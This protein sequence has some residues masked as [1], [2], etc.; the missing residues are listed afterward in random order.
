MFTGML[1]VE[2]ENRLSTKWPR[3]EVELLDIQQLRQ[4]N[5]QL[6]CQAN[7]YKALHGRAK[8]KQDQLSKE[9]EQLKARIRYLQKRLY[10]RKSEKSKRH[11]K[12]AW[13]QDKD[14]SCDD[15]RAR[16]HQRGAPGHARRDY[17][18]LPVKQEVYDLKDPCCPQCGL[19]YDEAPFVD[20]EDSQQIE[21]E[22]CAHRRRIHRKTYKKCCQCDGVPGIVTAPGPGKLIPKG[23]FGVSIW[24]TILLEKYSYQRPIHRLLDAFKDHEIDLA[25]GTIGDGLKRIAPLFEPVLQAISEKHQ[26]QSHM[27][28]DETRWLVF[29]LVEGKGS[30]RWYLWVFVSPITAVY[31]LDP[32]RSA[33]VLNRH[34]DAVAGVI[35]NVDRYAAYKSYAADRQSVILA[36]CWTHVRRDF[37]DTANGFAVLETW[38]M[39]WVELIGGI[40]HL[41]R[42]RL[43]HEVGSPGFAAAD[44]V[45]R[46]GL[47]TMK[48]RFEEELD[49]AHLHPEC[50]K[51]LN[52]LK[53]HWEGLTV[54]VDHP[55]VPMD[56]SE[57]ERQLR[58]VAL[59][60]KNY[61]G[62][63]SVWSGHFAACMFSIFQTLK[64]WQINPRKWL[65]AYLQACAARQA[66]APEQIEGFLPWAMSP[67]ELAQFRYP[68]SPGID[69]S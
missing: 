35:L 21:V 33:Q 12:Q 39:E 19:P 27:H 68:S 42:Q 14:A 32:S 37:L 56:N 11:E 28:A 41:N 59:G 60:R 40:F 8:A 61:Y 62:S 57:A 44:Q 6:R 1:A 38:A 7:F 5:R 45:L 3:P 51:R 55:W 65:T 15:Q 67:E 29:E 2:Q 50:R 47:D 13:R 22:V 52:S 53:E 46:E 63:G 17:S 10:A 36:F 49:D 69:S 30:Y 31:I 18:H 23:T 66:R 25:A 4:E 16:G 43:E 24:V 48:A 9:I 54:F 20:T 34:L 64:L 58:L 26:S